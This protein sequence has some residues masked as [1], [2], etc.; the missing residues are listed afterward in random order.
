MDKRTAKREAH[1]IVSVIIDQAVRS[2]DYG[3][4]DDERENEL[5]EQALEEISLGHHRIGTRGQE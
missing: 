2:N 4:S 3:W 1:R 5:I